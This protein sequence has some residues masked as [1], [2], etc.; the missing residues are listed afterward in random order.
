MCLFHITVDS[1]KSLSPS[2]D[3]TQPFAVPFR[4]YT[5]NSY[6]GSDIRHLV[7]Q[8]FH[9]QHHMDLERNSSLGFYDDR[10]IEPSLFAE[11]S[12][13]AENYSDYR[14][15]AGLFERATAP[16]MFTDGNL[17][18]KSPEIKPESDLLC[19]RLILNGAYKCMKCSK[20]K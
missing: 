19:S 17:H 11:R 16:G 4:P 8:T 12:P 18:G 5:W 15:A 9:H 2:V 3:E 1:E 13:G 10:A 6:S 20:V 7:Q 14:A